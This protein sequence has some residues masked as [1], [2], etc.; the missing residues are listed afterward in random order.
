M[1]TIQGV[2]R[3]DRRTGALQR[4]RVEGLEVWGWVPGQVRCMKSTSA[5]S[6]DNIELDLTSAGSNPTCLATQRL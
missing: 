6:W 4:L 1:Q 5:G 2:S 3:G